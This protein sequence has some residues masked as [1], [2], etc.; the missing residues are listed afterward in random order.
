MK[1]RFAK[2]TDLSALLTFTVFAVCILLVLLY[3]ARVYGRLVQRGEESFRLRTATQYL[4]T[5][6]QQAE[7][8]SLTEFDGCEALT[9][10]EQ[11]DGVS[12]VTRVYCYDGYLRELF[13]PENAALRPED[14]EKITP[15]A[16]LQMK[17]EAELLTI[18]LDGCRLLLQLRGKAG[19]MP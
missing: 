2:I 1:K 7:S 9:I 17:L 4:Y 14:G 13:C 16:Q 10:K 15:A 6:V 12:Y 18:D 19:A 3:G 11:T 8:V 5:R